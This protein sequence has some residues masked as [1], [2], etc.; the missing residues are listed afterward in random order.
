MKRIEPVVSKKQLKLFVDFPHSLYEHEP[1]Y[2]PELFI[3]QK[4]LL[5]PG[6]HPFYENAEMQLFLAYDGE[7]ITGRIAAI[8]NFNHN[9]FNNAND[10]FFGFFDCINDSETAGL[11]LDAAEKWLKEK[12]VTD[13]IMG[14]MN[15]STN[16]TCGM[17]VDG[18]EK[19]PMVMMTHNASYYKDLVE[20]HGYTKQTDLMAYLY[21]TNDYN[22]A[23][24]RRLQA[25]AQKRLEHRNIVIRKVNMKDFSNEA[26]KIKAVY[27]SAWD[28]NLGFYPMTDKE[29]K[30]TAKDLKMILDP[31]FCIVAEHEGRII[32]FALALPNINE[33]L[34]KIKRGRLFPTGLIKLLAGKSKVTSLRII[35]L[36]V[37]EGYRKSGIEMSFYTTIID[38]VLKRKRIREVEASWVLEDNILMN[39]AIQ[40]INGVPY[41]RYRIFEKKML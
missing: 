30:Y 2:V 11:L 6:K 33:V 34:I 14:P 40:D 5:T 23:R 21:Q 28:K 36:G 4:D 15:P 3:A 31:D 26:D 37:I 27:N 12:G 1:T 8:L 13:K 35:M 9:K 16:E 25:L 17:L 7:K 18:F 10:G 22:D 24:I 19:P 38:E 29:F 39:K 20:Q 41:K 32:G